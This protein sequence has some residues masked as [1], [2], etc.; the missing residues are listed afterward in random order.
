MSLHS[1]IIGTILQ[2]YIRGTAYSAVHPSQYGMHSKQ[3]AIHAT[4]L[5]LHRLSNC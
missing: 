1:P 3:C 5:P 4:K 2:R